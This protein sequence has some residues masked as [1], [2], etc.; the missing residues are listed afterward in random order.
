M[1]NPETRS[2]PG[3]GLGLPLARRLIE[4]MDGAFALESQPGR[5]TTITITLP[6]AGPDNRAAG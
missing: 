3:T 4:T 6:V 2:E 1:R 5:G